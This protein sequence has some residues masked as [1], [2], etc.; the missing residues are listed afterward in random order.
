MDVYTAP[1]DLIKK[2]KLFLLFSI[3]AVVG[4]AC[5]SAKSNSDAKID[6]LD[7]KE[8]PNTY[9]HNFA[10]QKAG[11]DHTRILVFADRTRQDTLSKLYTG[12]LEL[13]N[14]SYIAIDSVTQIASLATTYVGFLD[15]IN[16]A[17]YL[18]FVDEYD[19]VY[20]K[21]VKKLIETNKIQE[22]GGGDQLNYE[23]FLT[24]KPLVFAYQIEG[25]SANIINRLQELNIPVLNCTDFKESSPLGRAEWL[26]VFGLITKKSDAAE[27][28]FKEI[29]E[30]Y[31]QTQYFCSTLK[32]KPTVFSGSLFSGVWNVSGGKSFLAQ[33]IKD[34][35][36]TYEFANDTS[37]LNIVLSFEKVFLTCKSTDVWL[38]PSYYQTTKEI[39][40]EDER[41]GLFSAFKNHRVY[42][43]T[44]LQNGVSGNAY[45]EMGVV[46]PD[47]V[48]KDIA[49]CLH[50][51][52]FQGNTTI[53][54]Q[55]VE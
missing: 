35:G 23:A 1:M 26:K 19:Y 15:A 4:S 12:K 49:Q 43:N 46:R 5:N 9:A 42:N 40:Q 47:I 18:R 32:T 52:I 27:N 13:T 17:N 45:W 10:I 29:E 36:G 16:S 28:L 41:Y 8:T 7:W 38:N 31:T 3:I 39:L 48:L 33:M 44:K 53:F 22:C 50:P 6:T 24:S 11:E 14:S 54:Y 2:N 51:A 21:R 30:H 20:S 25:G 34:A 37:E 55:A